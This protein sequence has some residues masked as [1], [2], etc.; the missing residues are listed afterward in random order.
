MWEPSECHCTVLVE[1]ILRKEGSIGF[2]MIHEF[3]LALL[4][5]QLWRLVEFPDSLVAR[6]LRGRYYHLSSPLW[7]GTAD[8][9]SY[10]WTSITAA[11]KLLLLGIRSKVH[12]G[13]EINVW[14]DLWIPSSPARP[15]RARAAAVNPKMI[16][17]SLIKSSY[18]GMGCS[19]TGTIY[20]SR[21]YS[22]D[23][24]FGHKPYPSTWYILLELHKKWTVY[25]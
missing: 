23:P 10:V 4:A 13:Y 16:V 8:T 24:E 3:N 20:S 19:F 15:A 22:A 1:L 18:K 17:S 12:S 21:R 5:K 11:R 6:V 7:M 14:G 9:P 2:R 25:C